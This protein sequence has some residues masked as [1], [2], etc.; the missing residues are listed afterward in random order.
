MDLGALQ[1]SDSGEPVLAT[2]E[3]LVPEKSLQSTPQRDLYAA[4]L[5]FG[6][7]VTGEILP[8]EK[9]RLSQSDPLIPESCDEILLR[10]LGVEEPYRSTRQMLAW[11]AG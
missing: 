11:V 6:A 9:A 2:P 3:Y 7:L 1:R 10:G 4:A 5:T 8:P